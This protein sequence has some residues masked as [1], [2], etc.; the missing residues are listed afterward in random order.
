MQGE[1]NAYFSNLLDPPLSQDL[2][3]QLQSQ[4]IGPLRWNEALPG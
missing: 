1:L 2:I 3:I 4:R